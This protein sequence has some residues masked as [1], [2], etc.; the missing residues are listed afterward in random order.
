MAMP[1]HQDQYNETNPRIIEMTEQEI[2]ALIARIEQAIETGMAL[3]TAD[4]QLTLQ[5]IHT[6]CAVQSQ[7]HNKDATLRKLRGLLDIAVSKP[8]ETDSAPDQEPLNDEELAELEARLKDK[9]AA[10]KKRSRHQKPKPKTIEHKVVHHK[11]TELIK[12]QVCPEC[13]LGQLAKAEPATLL[14]ISSHEPY[15]ATQHVSEQ[16]KCNGCGAVFTAPLP[17]DVA[18]DGSSKQQYGYS[19]RSMITLDKVGLG[20][21][22]YR[23]DQMSTYTGFRIPSSTASDQISYVA[24]DTK[25]VCDELLIAAAN[26]SLFLADDT[27]HR[28]L[29][30]KEKLK[31]DR[32]T[33][34]NKLRTGVKSSCVISYHPD[35]LPI[36]LFNTDIGHT[37]EF[38]DSILAHRALDLPKPLV[39]TDAS[40]Q[41]TVTVTDVNV[42]LCLAHAYRKFNELKDISQF[43]TQATQTLSKAWEYRDQATLNDFDGQE[44]LQLHT[45]Q[46][47]PLLLEF[48]QACEI[49]LASDDAEEHSGLGKAIAYFL[50]HFEGL[51]AFCRYIG[52][53]LD[54]NE[55]EETLKR[56]ILARK[57]AYF[58]KTEKSAGEFSQ[59]LGLIETGKRCGL[60]LFDY[61]TTLQS[62][63][64]AVV[65]NVKA[66]LPW[67]FSQ[68]AK[69]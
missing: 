47:Y 27:S 48:K 2:D 65:K 15:E 11:L 39:M 40:S 14:R 20:T 45:E 68:L 50:R 43:A 32:K 35:R 3:S 29:S 30:E 34:K 22:Y 8:Q 1:A 59:L 7:L 25:I 52:A 26:G 9:K 16:L 36:V 57:N 28:I 51:T 41:N 56:I 44:T 54:N 21:P 61:L 5:A 69:V 64:S 49:Y 67:N 42:C 37:G 46:T 24:R 55:C 62:D 6:L 17:D 53:P 60:N 18:R 66:Y 33:G 10:Q 4:L 31:P 13:G 38:L 58:F 19:A 63:Y 23:S 12:G